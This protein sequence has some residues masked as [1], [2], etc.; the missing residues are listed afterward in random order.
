MGGSK[1]ILQPKNGL[2]WIEPDGRVEGYFTTEERAIMD[3]IIA[4]CNIPEDPPY[5]YYYAD[6]TRYRV[7]DESLDDEDNEDA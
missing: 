1:D 7:R 2:L 4:I 5:S 6:N 3:C